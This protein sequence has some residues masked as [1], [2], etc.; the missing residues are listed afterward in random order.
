M[1]KIINEASQTEQPESK[2]LLAAEMAAEAMKTL[3]PESRSYFQGFL[4]GLQAA[5]EKKA[6]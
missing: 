2:A 6:G 4:M 5:E 1:E 3:S